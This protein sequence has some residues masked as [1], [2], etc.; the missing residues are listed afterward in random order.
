MSQA[1]MKKLTK[2]CAREKA[3]EAEAAD[4]AVSRTQ[5]ILYPDCMWTILLNVAFFKPAP[6][7]LATIIWNNSLSFEL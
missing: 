5:L 4:R 1:Q 3:K 2:I 7:I 6:S